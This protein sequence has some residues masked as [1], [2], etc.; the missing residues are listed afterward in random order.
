MLGTKTQVKSTPHLPAQVPYAELRTF[1]FLWRPPGVGSP[2]LPSSPWAS[3]RWSPC[4]LY[5]G[6]LGT[7]GKGYSPSKQVYAVGPGSNTFWIF[8]VFFIKSSSG[9]TCP[10][11]SKQWASLCH[12]NSL[13]GIFVTVPVERLGFCV[14]GTTCYCY[15]V[16]GSKMHCYLGTF[17]LIRTQEQIFKTLYYITITL[18]K[19]SNTTH[20]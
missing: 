20:W 13:W 6:A 18:W 4:L 11:A 8:F 3:S 1:T 7:T 16:F 14:S 12:W 15:V 10:G 19:E 2:P 9:L 17:F 5:H